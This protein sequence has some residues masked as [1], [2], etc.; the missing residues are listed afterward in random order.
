M[1][2]PAFRGLFPHGGSRNSSTWAGASEFDTVGLIL[3]EPGDCIVLGPDDPEDGG[4]RG[5]HHWG[6]GELIP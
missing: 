6:F 3:I 5:R 2:F 4:T 1:S